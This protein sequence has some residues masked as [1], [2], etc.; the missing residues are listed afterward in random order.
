MSCCRSHRFP[1]SRTFARARQAGAI[2]SGSGDAGLALKRKRREEREREKRTH[3]P[4]GGRGETRS[5]LDSSLDPASVGARAST[6]AVG[7]RLQSSASA[8]GRASPLVPRSAEVSSIE[9]FLAS[10]ATHRR[11]RCAVTSRRSEAIDSTGL[12]QDP[13]PRVEAASRRLS[14]EREARRMWHGGCHAG[15]G[16]LVLISPLLGVL[17]AG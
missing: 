8:S 11:R 2:V 10:E 3:P 12:A 15:V 13:A 6:V 14:M 9:M 1:C 16:S 17:L 4:R 7:L 5:A